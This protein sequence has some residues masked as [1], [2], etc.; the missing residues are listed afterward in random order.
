LNDHGVLQKGCTV[1]MAE[2]EV[3]LCLETTT[4][5][6]SLKLTPYECM[7]LAEMLRKTANFADPQSVALFDC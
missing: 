2:D 4:Q 3:L 1:I 5:S 7:R 6:A